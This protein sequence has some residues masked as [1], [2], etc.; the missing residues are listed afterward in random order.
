MSGFDENAN[1]IRKMAA[2]LGIPSDYIERM[3]RD[4]NT[5]FLPI[6]ALLPLR[7]E[8]AAATGRLKKSRENAADVRPPNHAYADAMIEMGMTMHAALEHCYNLMEESK[9]SENAKP[10]KE[11]PN[12]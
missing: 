12:G 6:A 2:M 5:I 9:A 10:K 1:E 8:I 7:G 11:N 4:V 3:L